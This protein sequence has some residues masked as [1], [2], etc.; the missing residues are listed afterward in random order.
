MKEGADRLQLPPDVRLS[1]KSYI[2]GLIL[3]PFY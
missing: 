1:S 2:D 3:V